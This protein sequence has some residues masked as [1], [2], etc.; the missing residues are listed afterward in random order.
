MTAAG[1][2]SAVLLAALTSGGGANETSEVRLGYGPDRPAS[3]FATAA[4]KPTQ[5]RPWRPLSVAPRVGDSDTVFRLTAPASSPNPR[6]PANYA[7]FDLSGPGGARCRGQL[8]ARFGLGFEED[9]DVSL[10]GRQIR[11]L[12]PQRR[13]PLFLPP[14]S[15]DPGLDRQPWCPGVYRVA[16]VE[17]RFKDSSARRVV[18]ELAFKVRRQSRRARRPRLRAR[19]GVT[20]AEFGKDI[21]G[22]PLDH[23]LARLG[24]PKTVPS[25]Y[26]R[27][28]GQRCFY[29]DVVFSANSR[30][31]SYL[32]S[33]WQFCSR[34]GRVSS[35]AGSPAIPLPRP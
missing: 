2:A 27:S 12:P 5:P 16:A 4:R 29:Y 10:R 26:R 25:E 28:D 8:R 9:D 14:N 17:L 7:A 19:H 24:E 1:G 35:A 15:G 3:S 34:R 32:L 23:L 22:I 30:R 20:R 11:Y 21:V 13:D 33:P 31:N 18:G 6:A